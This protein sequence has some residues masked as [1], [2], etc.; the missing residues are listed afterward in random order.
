MQEELVELNH[1]L[2][3]NL[4]MDN[5]LI[6]VLTGVNTR[7]AMAKILEYNDNPPVI[8]CLES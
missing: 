1:E 7:K 2:A 8:I 5:M 4:N 3:A 6:V